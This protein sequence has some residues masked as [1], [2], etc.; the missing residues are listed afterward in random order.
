M[1]NAIDQTKEQIKVMQ[2]FVDGKSI[3]STNRADYLWHLN[4]SPQWDWHRLDYR[5]IKEPV[6][7][8]ATV[9]EDGSAVFTHKTRQLAELNAKQYSESNYPRLYRAVLLREVTP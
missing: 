4:V 2:A 8:W 9:N 1:G 6:E 7:T 5:V 3:E